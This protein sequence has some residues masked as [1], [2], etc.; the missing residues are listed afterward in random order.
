MSS[1]RATGK[2]SLAPLCTPSY[3]LRTRELQP[4]APHWLQLPPAPVHWTFCVQLPRDRHTKVAHAGELQRRG[5]P[6]QNTNQ[7]QLSAAPSEHVAH[8]INILLPCRAM[9]CCCQNLNLSIAPC[10]S[11]KGLQKSIRYRHK[12]V[13]KKRQ[14][15]YCR[16][17]VGLCRVIS[18]INRV[19]WKTSRVIWRA[20]AV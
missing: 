16:V 20:V 3:Y 4:P 11:S 19:F 13:C 2:L 17:I 6:P 10:L 14:L 5:P 7:V 18:N 1:H 9:L 12:H 8:H 15:V